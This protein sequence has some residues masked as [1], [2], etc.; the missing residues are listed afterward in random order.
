[1]HGAL[2]SSSIVNLSKASRYH[3][4]VKTAPPRTETPLRL[5]LVRSDACFNCGLCIDAC[6]YGVHH[7]Q[8]D[9]R[10]PLGEVDQQE[11]LC[12]SC[13]R[14]VRECPKDALSVPPNEE[15]RHR[16]YGSWTAE[17]ISSILKQAETGKVPVSGQGY[18]GK[19][20][21]PGFDGI[22]TDMSEIVRPTR[23]GIH[24]REYISTAIVVGSRPE[25]VDPYT[26]GAAMSRM[27]E[28]P[29][30]FLFDLTALPAVHPAVMKTLIQAA[31]K[32][33]T[34][35]FADISQAASVPFAVPVFRPDQVK[36]FD[37]AADSW[38]IELEDGPQFESA[39]HTL[40]SNMN[41]TLLS[42]RIPFDADR[43]LDLVLRGAHVLHLRTDYHGETPLGHVSRALRAV[44][45]KLVDAGVRERVTILTGGAIA[46]AEHIPKTILLGADGVTMDLS[47]LAAIELWK[48]G[49]P[50]ETT[51]NS[52]V[53]VDVPWGMQRI[54]NLMAAWRDQL[55]EI[56]GAMG[57]REVRRLR[58][59]V[60]RGLFHEDL[61]REFKSVFG[62]A[63]QPPPASES[64]SVVSPVIPKIT[65][66][67]VPVKRNF[68]N[69][70]SKFRVSVTDACIH[71]GVC[72]DTCP[73]GVF[74]M[75]NGFNKLLPP[76]SS[77]CIGSACETKDFYCVP[78]CPTDAIKI[79]VDPTYQGM[80][81][82]RWT[83]DLL[84]AT[85]KQA[86]EGALPETPLQYETGASEGGFDRI[87]FVATEVVTTSPTYKTQVRK[88]DDEYRTAIP[89]NRRKE[90]RQLWIPVPWYGGGMSYGSISLHVMIARAKAAKAFGTFMS[91]GEG[92]YPDQLIPYADHVITQ[93][94]TGLFG[95]REDTMRRARI[96]EFK[97][98]Q[99]AKP[100]LGGHLLADKVTAEVAKM[101]GSVQW[102]SLFSPFP[103]HSVY[104]VEDHK[105]HLDWVRVVNPDALISV[106]VST[107]SDVDMV[108]VGSYYAGANILQLDG[109]YGGTGA[110]P[111][112]AKKNIAMPIEFAIPKVH[113]FLINEG[114]RD[115]MVVLASGGVRSASDILKSIALGADGVVVG[116]AELVAIECDR[117]TNC[118]RG[119]GCPFG[120]ATSDPD[121]TNLIDPDWAAQR[122]INLYHSWRMQILDTLDH[123]G[124]ETL[125]ELRGRTD[126]LE[127]I[128]E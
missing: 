77:E 78:K 93:V 95:V 30:P 111:D 67:V 37:P 85:Y 126:L 99:G 74:K 24:G 39:F 14:C 71:C 82:S 8:D 107:P 19:F 44:H 125:R 90:G 92:G 22:W 41:G 116:T 117:C 11:T 76:Q 123:L 110:A 27:I 73:Y 2:K 122:I 108:A 40:K 13:L 46:A 31:E 124:L 26:R 88:N 75:P 56:L 58:G 43:A 17:A 128:D 32:L 120:I 18:R 104:S 51:V 63:V 106:K 89:L 96:V 80:G 9:F 47:L 23:D 1:M 69:E 57:M 55:L 87:R 105:K 100:G 7:R 16:S 60:G 38:M 66:S 59:E 48:G 115:E 114:I 12:R 34:L 4:A 25:S 50:D 72:V 83:G 121:L 118:E 94:A 15:Y 119:R 52:N 49:A 81:D 6:I 91:T 53:L 109:S 84:L 65:A 45:T 79:D 127:Y 35:I 112:I 61:L 5:L 10:M 28:I 70:L 86:E 97:Y 36:Q 101:R 20:A 102:S 33:Q 29:V 62:E 42:V 64:S 103:F 21:G 98:A 3:I 113:R 68:H 54:C